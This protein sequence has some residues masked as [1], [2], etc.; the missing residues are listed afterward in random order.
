[1]PGADSDHVYDCYEKFQLSST[2]YIYNR[3]SKTTVGQTTRQATRREIHEFTIR[4][5]EA[6]GYARLTGGP[7]NYGPLPGSADCRNLEFSYGGVKIPLSSCDSILNLAG[8]SYNQSGTV[9]R[10]RA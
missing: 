5:R 8:G 6:K 9:H 10:A 7:F 2:Q 4:F 1:M 3:Y